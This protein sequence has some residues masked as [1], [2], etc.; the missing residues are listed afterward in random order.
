MRRFLKISI[1]LVLM[2]GIVGTLSL[3]VTL[4]YYNQHLPNHQQLANYEP[5]TLSRIYSSDGKLI[6]EYATEKRIFVPISSIPK[7]VINAFISAEDKNFYNHI[8]IDFEGITRAA[9][10]NLTSGKRWQGASTIHQQVAKNML[11]SSERT[12]ER[13]LKEIIL[14]LRINN[15]F[16]REKILE[17]YLNEI[18]LG[19]G[20]YG[21]AAAAFNY[22]NKPI[23]EINT[24]EAALLAALPKAPST[25]NPYNDYD[26]AM[27]RRNWVLKRMNSE[28]YISNYLFKQLIQSPIELR[29]A[30]KS[31]LHTAESYTEEARKIIENHF[32]KE[33]LYEEGLSVYTAIDTSLQKMA[34]NALRKGLSDY[35]MRHG[36][37]GPVA[38]SPILEDWPRTL[39]TQAHPAELKDWKLAIVLNINSENKII[40]IGVEPN[41]NSFIAFDD[42]KWAEK[43]AYKPASATITPVT[44]ILQP[45]DIIVVE[46]GISPARPHLLRQIPKINGALVAM[47]V[48]TGNVLSMVGGFSTASAQINRAT[49]AKRQPGSAFKPFVYLKALENGYNG[50]DLVNDEPIEFNKITG[51]RHTKRLDTNSQDWAAEAEAESRIWAPQNHSGNFYGPTTLRSALEKSRNVSTIHLG[52]TLGIDS[53]SEITKRF[54]ISKQPTKNFASVL[55]TGETTLI[56]LTSAYAMIANGGKQITPSIITRIQNRRGETIF[57]NDTRLCYGCKINSIF[58]ASTSKIPVLEENRLQIT[59]PQSAYQLTS[60]LEGVVQNGTGRKAK[61]L[62]VPIAGKTGTTQNSNDAWFVGYTPNLVVGVYAG[63]DTPKSLGKYEEGSSVAVPIFVNFM[64]QAL[65][66]EKA[67]PFPIPD[68]L[69]RVKIDS[70]TGFL[71]SVD[72]P[73]EDIITESFKTGRVPTTSKLRTESLP[74]INRETESSSPI[75]QPESPVNGI[76]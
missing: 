68:G 63:F 62:G 33:T 71:P 60:I 43:Q 53:I 10:H 66:G 39:E 35:S 75:Q 8:G 18:Y 52:L 9:I 59:D 17:L 26:R 54:G 11:L 31:N 27:E 67:S 12:I 25:S 29:T 51:E 20:S 22:F 15:S 7:V 3:I 32:T 46:E 74:V 61:V 19:A 23:T 36:F 58:D 73:E 5:K 40:E 21:V 69:K 30:P 1:Y 38:T 64:K 50:A 4:V 47:D 6:K 16:E 37:H 72:T 28:G 57:K 2:L 13:K 49:Q 14:A 24:Q 55:G 42:I 56:E 34:E 76:Y 48:H 65:K 44:E 45:G 41:Q 70:R